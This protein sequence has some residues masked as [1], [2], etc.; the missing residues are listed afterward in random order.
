MISQL[1]LRASKNNKLENLI[2]RMQL[3]G[4]PES[5]PAGSVSAPEATACGQC[6]PVR[7]ATEA[8][9]VFRRPL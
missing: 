4:A 5:P 8:G 9:L 6:E 2:S 7:T 1:P 3:T